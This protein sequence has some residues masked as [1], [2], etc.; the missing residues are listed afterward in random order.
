MR[1]SLFA[2]S[3]SNIEQTT[4]SD[5]PWTCIE[6]DARQNTGMAIAYQEENVEVNLDELE[7][8]D[9]RS[10]SQDGNEIEKVEWDPDLPPFVS[11][12]LKTTDGALNPNHLE[13]C[14]IAQSQQC[15]CT[16]FPFALAFFVGFLFAPLSLTII[17][18]FYLFPCFP[19]KW[20][21]DSHTLCATIGG[22]M[23]IIALTITLL[24]L[25]EAESFKG[26]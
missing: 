2:C 11:P 9:L 19:Q 10:L 8:I 18:S 14:R 15:N 12:E 26:S 24:A 1:R 21:E 5:E 23:G 17:G 22:A 25:L 20:R 4:D 16:L 13:E 6:I 3:T 7:E